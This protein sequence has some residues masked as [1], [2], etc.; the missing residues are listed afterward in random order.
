MLRYPKCKP[1][2]ATYNSI[3]DILM[4]DSEFSCHKTKKILTPEDGKKVKNRTF[5]KGSFCKMAAPDLLQT[6]PVDTGVN[7]PNTLRVLK[8]HYGLIPQSER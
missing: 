2:E 1:P 5:D 7:A 8:L 3:E 4:Q 6:T